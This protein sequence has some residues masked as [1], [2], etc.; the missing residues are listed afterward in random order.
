MTNAPLLRSSARRAW[1]GLATV[2]VLGGSAC[3]TEGELGPEIRAELEQGL[4]EPALAQAAVQ[5]LVADADAPVVASTT[6]HEYVGVDSFDSIAD[7]DVVMLKNWWRGYLGCAADDDGTVGTH[8]PTELDPYAWI[9]HRTD[10][11]GDGTDEL[12]FEQVD[13]ASGTGLYLKMNG[14]GEV[15]CGEITGIGDAAAW[16]TGSL[17]V[18]TGNYKRAARQLVSYKQ[19]LCLQIDG[20]DE[21]ASATCNGFMH[22]LFTFE[23][24]DPA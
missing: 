13:G 15:Y 7:G 24:I 4:D 23:L 22:K 8:L 9:V 18:S 5:D 14:S 20:N 21:G 6:V 1:I 11:D 12:Q 16:S 19:G 3:D 10:L 17:F 2:A